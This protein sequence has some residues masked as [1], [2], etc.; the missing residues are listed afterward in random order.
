MSMKSNKIITIGDTRC[1][2][3]SI[4]SRFMSNTFDPG[5]P[6]TVGIDWFS[7]TVFFT[8]NGQ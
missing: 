8:R 4:L 7:K 5:H 2:K 3:T 6:T 1:G